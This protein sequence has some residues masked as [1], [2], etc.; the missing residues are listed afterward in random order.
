M[1]LLAS[2]VPGWVFVPASCHPPQVSPVD[3][4]RCE[5]RCLP[6]SALVHRNAAT[7]RRYSSLETNAGNLRSNRNFRRNKGQQIYGS[8]S[9]TSKPSF[10]AS[11]LV[12]VVWIIATFPRFLQEIGR[13]PC[14][15][16]KTGC[17]STPHAWRCL[18]HNRARL[19]ASISGARRRCRCRV[20]V[21]S[22]P[23]LPPNRSTAESRR[24]LR[25][26]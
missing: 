22:A 11:H 23:H 25:S 24:P 17:G 8:Y 21:P 12:V 20:P 18:P 26:S 16:I 7:R 1:P 9:S 10:F 15:H 3:A 2:Q 5:W 4:Q 19:L 14:R 13:A 6:A